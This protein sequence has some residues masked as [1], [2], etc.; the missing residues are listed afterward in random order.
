MDALA[1]YSS[2]S[3]DSEDHGRQLVSAEEERKEE[4]R[5]G[6]GEGQVLEAGLLC[7]FQAFIYTS[8]II[9]TT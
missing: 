4:G 7:R 2:S 1:A 3:S 8:S 6:G 9:D 5:E